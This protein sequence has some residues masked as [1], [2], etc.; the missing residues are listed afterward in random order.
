MGFY[1]GA[2]SMHYPAATPMTALSYEFELLEKAVSKPHI[3]KYSATR[4]VG[5]GCKEGKTIPYTS[6]ILLLLFYYTLHI[7][8]TPDCSCGWHFPDKSPCNIMAQRIYGMANRV[9]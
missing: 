4:T 5:A 1:G 7:Q 9:V 3:R 2:G 6:V 8:T